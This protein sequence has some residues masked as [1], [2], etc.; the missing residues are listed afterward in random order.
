MKK[1]YIFLFFYTF[2]SLHLSAQENVTK[3]ISGFIG[4]EDWS[5]ENKVGSEQLDLI[6]SNLTD[7]LLV[8]NTRIK[9]FPNDVDKVPVKVFFSH[10]GKFIRV[11]SIKKLKND[12]W[13]YTREKA[14]KSFNNEIM[15][16]VTSGLISELPNSI[17]LTQMLS[18]TFKRYRLS[19]DAEFS[20]TSILYRYPKNGIKC[21]IMFKVWGIDNPLYIN[22][23]MPKIRKDRARIFFDLNGDIKI[24]DNFL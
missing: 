5:F 11:E 3:V 10:L 13:R 16:I 14:E 17:G 8:I 12:P 7:S 6:H 2:L 9:L 22:K 23:E 21:M 20:F 15:G 24:S 4:T 1:G 19:K 18:W